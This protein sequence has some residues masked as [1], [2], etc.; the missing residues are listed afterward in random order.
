MKTTTIIAIAALSCSAAF[1]RTPDQTAAISE[2]YL[3][4]VDI[5]VENHRNEESVNLGA[6][7]VEARDMAVAL[8]SH[9]TDYNP[10]DGGRTEAMINRMTNSI[11]ELTL[12][13]LDEKGVQVNAVV[14]RKAIAVAPPVVAIKNPVV[15]L[16][17]F[18]SAYVKS[19]SS[20]V[21]SAILEATFFSA[22]VDY[23]D[24]GIVDRNFIAKDIRDYSKRWPNRA[25]GINGE[26]TFTEITPNVVRA[27]FI[28]AFRVSNN[29]KTVSG[30]VDTALMINVVN[31]APE[32][33]SVK[34]KT[35]TRREV[36][37]SK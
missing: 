30:T 14:A 27:R 18:V 17:A 19:G 37:A 5:I 4:S 31:N 7:R 11:L 25:M 12:S 8:L 32:I 24:D 34:S 10:G 22:S 21:E 6:L 29:E 28:L 35:V 23:F 2:A 20:N 16:A 13:L 15:D 33:V 1:A 36:V 9:T 26:I 3:E